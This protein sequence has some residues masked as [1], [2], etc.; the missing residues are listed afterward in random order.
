M[1]KM[2]KTIDAVEGLT[3][4]F[5]LYRER[6]HESLGYRTPH[7]VYFGGNNNNHDEGDARRLIHQIQPIFLS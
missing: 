4:Y 5:Q 3:R 6:I 2:K 7:K 1:G